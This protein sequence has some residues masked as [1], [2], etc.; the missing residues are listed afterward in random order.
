[1]SVAEVL[2]GRDLDR[3]CGDHTVRPSFHRYQ[4]AAAGSCRGAGDRIQSTD[5]RRY[6]SGSRSSLQASIFSLLAFSVS[7]FAF[8]HAGSQLVAKYVYAFAA[9]SWLNRGALR[10]QLPISAAIKSCTYRCPY[11]PLS[12]AVLVY[13]DGHC[14][15]ANVKREIMRSCNPP[16]RPRHRSR[17]LVMFAFVIANHNEI[18]RNRYRGQVVV[19]ALTIHAFQ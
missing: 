13:L 16:S 9:E 4:A 15:G 14:S 17:L 10:G 6:V 7:C 2:G 8:V 11:G 12:G 19:L 1:V 3:G 5:L 18:F